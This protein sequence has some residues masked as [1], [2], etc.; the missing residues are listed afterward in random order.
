MAIL[1]SWGISLVHLDSSSTNSFFRCS[2]VEPA[3]YL[4]EAD[5]LIEELEPSHLSMETGA[6]ALDGGLQDGQGLDD[7]PLLGRVDLVFEDQAR[8]V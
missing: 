6:T 7:F 5:Q 8:Q 3:K 1:G 2:G 4:L